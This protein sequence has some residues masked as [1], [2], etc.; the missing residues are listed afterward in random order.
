M[1]AAG[2]YTVGW[3]CKKTVADP[4]VPAA[5]TESVEVWVVKTIPRYTSTVTSFVN[6]SELPN[7]TYIMVVKTTLL[8]TNYK[9]IWKG[10]STRTNSRHVYIGRELAVMN[11]S[12]LTA[13]FC[14]VIFLLLAIYRMI[15]CHGRPQPIIVSHGSQTR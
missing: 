5:S 14:L 12:I 7:L 6:E 13:F 3:V 10:C 4:M 2:D 15:T 1:K 8:L 11:P 9:D